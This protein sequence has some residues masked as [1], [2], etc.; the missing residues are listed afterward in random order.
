MLV[1]IQV[2]ITIGKYNTATQ[3]CIHIMRE[4]KKQGIVLMAMEIHNYAD[5]A[6]YETGG[7]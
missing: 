1:P 5:L 3:R 7:G 2:L 6:A 4:G